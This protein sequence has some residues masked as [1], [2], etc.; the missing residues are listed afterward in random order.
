MSRIGQA[1]SIWL[2]GT[3]PTQQPGSK[4]RI[5]PFN[6]ESLAFLRNIPV[7]EGVTDGFESENIREQ[8]SDE[9]PSPVSS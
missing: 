4:S 6:E 9:L 1:E 5:I 8:S 2:D 3:T 7:T